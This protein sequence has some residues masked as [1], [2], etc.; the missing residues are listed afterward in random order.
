MKAWG[1]RTSIL[2]AAVVVASGTVGRARAQPVAP[3]PPAM[4]KPTPAPIPDPVPPSTGR[5]M[6]VANKPLISVEVANKALLAAT[7]KASQKDKCDDVV[8]TMQTVL[9]Y[10]AVSVDE[11]KRALIAMQRDLV[12]RT[13]A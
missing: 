13:T 8:L 5:E 2:V 6:P 1:M 12:D 10:A 3:S 7:A 9:P 4:P 11:R